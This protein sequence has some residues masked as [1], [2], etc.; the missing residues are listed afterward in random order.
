MDDA[1]YVR[2]TRKWK[3]IQTLNITNQY[4]CKCLEI[5]ISYTLPARKVI[6]NLQQ[7]ID[8]YGKSLGI[9]TDNGPEFTSSIF[10]SWLDKNDIEWIKIQKR[11]PQL[12][13]IVERFN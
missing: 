4:N 3:E 5:A 13:A 12:N 2:F 10:Q 11:K 9:R 8:E 7:T 1:I 6:E